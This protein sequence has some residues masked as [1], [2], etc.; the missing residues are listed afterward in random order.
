LHLNFFSFPVELTTLSYA[1]RY[2]SSTDKLS[3]WFIKPDDKTV[4][5]FFHELEFVIPPPS[6]RDPNAGWKAKASH[7]CTPDTYDVQYEF[8]FQGVQLKEW[9]MEYTV[10]GPQKDYRLRSVYRR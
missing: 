7:F 4:D 10:K 9:I 1:H 5:Y 8:K 3:A 6:S 2:T